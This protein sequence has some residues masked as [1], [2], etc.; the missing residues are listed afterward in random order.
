MFDLGTLHRPR[1]TVELRAP[2]RKRE[3]LLLLTLALA[4]T[5]YGAVQSLALF[6]S[7]ETSS[8]NAFHAG[9][10]RLD[11][12]PVATKWFDLQNMAPG[13]TTTTT[14]SIANGGSLQLR[15]SIS[16]GTTTSQTSGD[17]GYLPGVM[18]AHLYGGG[19]AG[20]EFT[21][22]TLASFRYGA[23][24]NA[25][26]SDSHNPICL[27]IELPLSAGNAYQD[28]STGL[29]VTFYGEQTANNP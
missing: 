22:G 8:G 2:V 15:Y 26:S 21:S 3:R 28:K 18:L 24:L 11:L 1:A 4:L 17:P 12:T 23:T 27:K 6:T 7:S 10:L 25:S 16:T 29:T 5:F 13:D 14:F 19:C 20:T 9:T